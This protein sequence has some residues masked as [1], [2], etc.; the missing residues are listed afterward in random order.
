MIYPLHSSY[1]CDCKK[2]KGLA[3]GNTTRGSVT[4]SFD[5]RTFSTVYILRIFK[6]IHRF[7]LN[8]RSDFEPCVQ[9]TTMKNI[10]VYKYFN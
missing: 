7:T 2:Q 9:S 3:S 1:G 6:R 8:D 5:F 4:A 10:F